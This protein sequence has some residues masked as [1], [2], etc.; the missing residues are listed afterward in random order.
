MT[1]KEKIITLLERNKEITISGETL[2]QELGISRAAIWKAITELRKEGFIIDAVTNNGYRLSPSS[3]VLSIPGICSHWMAPVLSSSKIHIFKTT[4]STNLT[5]KKMALEGAPHGTVVIAETQTAGRG[6]M[7]RS[8]F[9]PSSSGIYMSMVLKPDFDTS[10]AVLVT[11]AASVAISRAIE[12]VTGLQAEI[13]WVNDLYLENKKICGILTEAMTNFE[14][15]EIETIVLG[16]GI[17]FRNPK[18][19][20]GEMLSNV[21]GALFTDATPEC[22]RNQLIAQ[23]IEELLSVIASLE[24]RQFIQEYKERSL[25]LGREINVIRGETLHPATVLDIDKDGG[26]IVQYKNDNLNEGQIATLNSGEISI[27]LLP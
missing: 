23:V 14:T 16:L 27:R 10:C 24:S 4:D 12:K 3:D 17:N 5:A 8:F 15:N 11:T 18:E 19:G 22:T 6:R 13:K 25:V 2:A 21:A 20:F 26:L 1:T 9:S 7:G